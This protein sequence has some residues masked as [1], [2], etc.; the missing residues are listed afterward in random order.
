MRKVTVLVVL[1]VLYL[2]IMLVDGFFDTVYHRSLGLVSKGRLGYVIWFSILIGFAVYILNLEDSD[3]QR[4]KKRNR[5]LLRQ[6][7]SGGAFAVTSTDMGLGS[8]QLQ[9]SITIYH[10]G[11]RLYIAQPT[12]DGDMVLVD[13]RFFTWRELESF[14][15]AETD[16][17]L[18][19]FMP[20][21]V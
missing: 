21:D 15:Q 9:A 11:F 1:V 4:I 17:A 19:D 18:D 5:L 13:R 8:V 6:I 10:A 20:A 14:L 16:F 12:M 2:A 3:R 7:K